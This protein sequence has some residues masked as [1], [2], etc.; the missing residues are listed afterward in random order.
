MAEGNLHNVTINYE[1][2]IDIFL[3]T[4]DN[5]TD[6]HMKFSLE[7]AD[8]TGRSSKITDRRLQSRN[9]RKE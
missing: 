8:E 6:Q 2:F 5:Q 1:S 9:P 7:K 3:K 4:Q